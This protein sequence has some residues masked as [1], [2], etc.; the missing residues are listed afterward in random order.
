LAIE[1]AASRINSMTV[2]EIA[3]R[4]A[5]DVLGLPAVCPRAVPP[6]HQSLRASLDW[7]NALLGG[8]ERRLLHRLTALLD[9]FTLDDA[10]TPGASEDLQPDEV[11]LLLDRLVAQS[12]VQAAEHDSRMR[13]SLA[14][15]VRAYYR[16]RRAD[17]DGHVSAGRARG[18]HGVAPAATTEERPR[19]C[20]RDTPTKPSRRRPRELS[21][22]ERDV[23]LLIARGRSNRQIADEL[24]ITKKTAEAHVSHIL[25]KLGLISRVQIATWGL[26][27]GLIR[28]GG[29]T[30]SS[31]AAPEQPDHRAA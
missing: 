16:E 1:L 21:E 10:L 24:V 4:I 22:R 26:Q 13:Y 3:D 6:R 9:N 15:P 29:A 5:D 19:E 27:H 30:V 12:V 14:A 7:S 28:G 18:Q 11:A 20:P 8:T 17:V 31:V 25:T 2:P 23:V